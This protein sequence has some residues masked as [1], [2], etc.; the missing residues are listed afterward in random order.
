MNA[1]ALPRAATDARTIATAASSVLRAMRTGGDL[2]GALDRLEGQASRTVGRSVQG[3]DSGG[4]HGAT[5]ED[6][7]AEAISQL[8]IGTTLLCAEATVAAPQRADGLQAAVISLED[9]AEA[10]DALQSEPRI[11]QGFD[12]VPGGRRLDVIEAALVAL[13]E[14]SQAAGGV[15]SAVLDKALQPLVKQVPQVLT[16]L[17]KE[18]NL[19][20]PGRLVR[21]GLRAVQRGLDLLLRLVDLAAIERQ[22]ATIDAVLGRLGRGEDS[23]VLAGWFIGA[24]S[25][26]AGLPAPDADNSIDDQRV[27]ELVRLSARFVRLCRLLRRTAILIAGIATSLLTLNVTVPQ[28]AAVTTVGLVLVL[29]VTVVVGRSYTGAT[30][31]PVGV[32]G[33]RLLLQTP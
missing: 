29:G 30:D 18:L 20:I 2:D 13:E 8:G 25:V 6:L 3:F 19:S 28:A 22:R 27:D 12:A 1:Q 15:A 4:E 14:M 16:D 23:E 21:W 33:V 26:R 32:R 24:D 11:A 17:D 9:T 7:V 31:L 10:I 5:E